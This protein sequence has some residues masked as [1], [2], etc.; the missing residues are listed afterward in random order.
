[1]ETPSSNP[2]LIKPVDLSIR[3]T[4]GSGGHTSP[5]ASI[6]DDIEIAELFKRRE[7]LDRDRTQACQQKIVEW[8]KQHTLEIEKREQDFVAFFQMDIATTRGKTLAFLRHQDKV[9]FQLETEFVLGK[10]R[11][12][13]ADRDAFDIEVA[14]VIDETSCAEEDIDGAVVANRVQWEKDLGDRMDQILNREMEGK[15]DKAVRELAKE[16]EGRMKA[17]TA[18]E[19]EKQARRTVE[20]ELE[21]AVREMAREREGRIMTAAALEKEKLSSKKYKEDLAECE[22]YIRKRKN[23]GGGMGW[24]GSDNLV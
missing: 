9:A 7:K 22:E 3:N 23:I 6:N 21:K 2:P 5:R 20:G 10:Q 12:E 14:R 11:R 19:K 17:V 18:L 8:A 1:M 15:L 4:P 16:R 13:I 24:D